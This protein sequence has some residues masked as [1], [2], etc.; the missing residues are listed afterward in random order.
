MDDRESGSGDTNM[1]IDLNGNEVDGGEWEDRDRGQ[2]EGDSRKVEGSMQEG[3]GNKEKQGRFSMR[4]RKLSVV[5]MGQGKW[6]EWEGGD[7]D[8][9]DDDDDASSQCNQDSRLG[10]RIGDKEISQDGSVSSQVCSQGGGKENKGKGLKERKAGIR[11]H[12]G[13]RGKGEG[14]GKDRQNSSTINPTILTSE[15]GP[16]LI[17]SEEGSCKEGGDKDEERGIVDEREVKG[18]KIQRGGFQVGNIGSVEVGDAG[19]SGE[20]S[21][22]VDEVKEVKEKSGI[23]YGIGGDMEKNKINLEMRTTL[24]AITKMMKTVI[25]KVDRDKKERDLLRSEQVELRKR[26]EERRTIEN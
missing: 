2:K 21:V 16:G 26:V 4:G 3:G 25:D 22:K 10:G 13:K 19:K 23:E 11:G 20:K 18:M 24:R 17:Q 8:W 6:S 9:E 5:K 7:N 1:D 14:K 12:K 15:T